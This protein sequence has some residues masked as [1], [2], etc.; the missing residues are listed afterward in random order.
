MIEILISKTECLQKKIGKEAKRTLLNNM[1]P[2]VS[3]SSFSSTFQC[4][5]PN[6]YDNNMSPFNLLLLSAN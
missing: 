3:S 4:K 5:F 1:N 2:N 6:Q